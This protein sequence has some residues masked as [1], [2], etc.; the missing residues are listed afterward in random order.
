MNEWLPISE[1]SGFYNYQEPENCILRDPRNIR[2]YTCSNCGHHMRVRGTS[3]G[4]CYAKKPFWQ[5]ILAMIS[6]V[7]PVLIVVL[8]GL[9]AVFGVL[10]A[11]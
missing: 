1:C 3:C 4:Y 11:V 6:A 7:A 2:L 5:V 9:V 10:Q 8:V